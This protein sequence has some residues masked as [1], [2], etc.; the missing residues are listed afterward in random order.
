MRFLFISPMAITLVPME[1]TA[2][3]SSEF[4]ELWGGLVCEVWNTTGY[5]F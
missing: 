1:Y 3:T 2:S 4:P 5:A